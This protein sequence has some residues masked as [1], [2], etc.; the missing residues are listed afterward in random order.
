[1]PGL[2]S[3]PV[4]ASVTYVSGDKLV[5]RTATGE[6]P[7]YMVHV[8]VDDASLQESGAYLSP[9]MPAVAYITTEQRTI[10]DYLLDPLL[11]NFDRALRESN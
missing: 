11:E 3:A 9:G 4:D 1:M 5:Q 6:V 10:M 2:A 7:Y 8:Q